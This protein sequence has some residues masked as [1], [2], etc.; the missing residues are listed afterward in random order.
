MKLVMIEWAD[1]RQP[2]HG[3]ERVSEMPARDYCKCISVGWLLQDNRDVKVLAANVAD[4]GDETQAMGIVTIPT[5]CVLK[6]TLL[7][8]SSRPA[9]KRTP[10]RT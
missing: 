7:T 2:T 6:L 3:W 9:S 1:S 5:A 10:Q 4:V 8:S